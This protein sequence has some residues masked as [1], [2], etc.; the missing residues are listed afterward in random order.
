MAMMQQKPQMA[1]PQM[2]AKDQQGQAPAQEQGDVNKLV[3]GVG[4]GL[5]KLAQLLPPEMAGDMAELAQK[6]KDLLAGKEE[7]EEAP[8]PA[9][10][11]AQSMRGAP[12]DMMSAGKGRPVL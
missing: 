10:Q 2:Q 12:V 1:A 9:E 7:E 11:A 5:E 6:Y 4:L 3:E 8:A